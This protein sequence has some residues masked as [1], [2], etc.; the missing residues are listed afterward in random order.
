MWL[1]GPSK[2]GALE[3]MPCWERG[4]VLVTNCTVGNDVTEMVTWGG[5]L[6]ASM[7]V[8]TNGALGP[9]HLTLL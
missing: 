1:C 8:L 2:C 4:G 6:I 5:G 9:Q 3:V 7:F